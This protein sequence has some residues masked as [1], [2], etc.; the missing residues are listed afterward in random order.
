MRLVKI[1]LLDGD[2]YAND[3][4]PT[5]AW[6]RE[7]RPV[8]W[9]EINELWGVARYDDIDTGAVIL[10][11]TDGTLGILG[12][13]RHD[14][15]GYDVRMEVI[16]SRDAVAVGLGARTPLRSVEVDGPAMPG[17]AWAT[18]LTRFED[19]YRAELVAFLRVVRGELPSP[20]TARD[21][22]EAVRISIAAGRSRKEHRP[23]RLSE[24][25]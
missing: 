8:Y 1:D 14:P 11:M 12:Q 20:C 23:I 19:A 25:G 3:P 6:L 18:F 2:L 16:G 10:R 5:Y 17:P 13:T 9:D 4:Y 15:L 24:I 22:L 7:H 21:G